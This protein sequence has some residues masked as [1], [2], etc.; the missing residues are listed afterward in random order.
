MKVHLITPTSDLT[1]SL[2]FYASLQFS[3]LS[4]EKPT[5][6]TDGKV[7]I[8]ID[9][10]RFVRPG[11]KVYT[12]TPEALATQ[13]GALV[14]VI[15]NKEG[16]LL[17]DPT[18]TTIYLSNQSFPA[19]ASAPASTSI[20]GNFAGISLETVD[21]EKTIAIWK[22]IGFTRQTGT[23]DQGWISLTNDHGLG[24]SIMKM[25]TCPHLFFNPSL[26]YFNGGENLKVIEKVRS[27]NIPITE[28]ITHFNNVG[29][30]DNIILRDPGGYG[31]F[32]FND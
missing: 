9:P 21:P 2:D 6:V 12:E 8:E 5:L 28:E 27:A 23:I 31:F 13:L 4:H 16:Y 25:N 20:L 22:A 32:V 24:V 17:Q 11:V 10:D 14:P 1:A 18:G 3:I 30:V 15:Q 26:T 19:L 29:I 7:V